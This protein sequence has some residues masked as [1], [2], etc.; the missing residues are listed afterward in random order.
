MNPNQFR[1][2]APKP[3]MHTRALPPHLKNYVILA[4]PSTHFRPATCE[5]VRCRAFTI[6]WETHCDE[7]VA[8][9]KD[10]AAW[11]RRGTHGNKYDEYRAPGSSI[12]VF[13]FPPFQPRPFGLE[14][15]KHLIKIERPELF[16]YRDVSTGWDLKL[17]AGA[18]NGA[19][20]WVDDF[21]T[22]QDKVARKVQE[23]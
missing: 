17:H 18:E 4:P 20:D 6:G 13:R 21:A 16:A 15:R 7:A 23:G 1:I 19:R 9:L 5:Q 10:L 8:E 2:P 11:I 14:H 22:N 12:T 3:P